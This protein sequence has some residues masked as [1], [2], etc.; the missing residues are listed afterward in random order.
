MALRL[1]LAFS[2]LAIP[3][4][5]DDLTLS[6]S[7][8]AWWRGPNS[9]GVANANP[10]V[11]TT[12]DAETNI[13][14]RAPVPGRG[15]G[16]PVIVGDKVFLATADE[17]SQVQSVICFSRENGDVLWQTEV[18]RGGFEADGR[19]GHPRSTKASSTV[20]CDGERVFTNFWNDNA[21]YTTALDMD[22]KQLWQHKITDYTMH[23]GYGSSPTIYGPLVIVS[24]DNKGGGAIVGLDR[25][26]GKEV[27]RHQRPEKPNYCSPIVHNID[28]K[29]QVILVGCDKILSLD[30]LT[31]KVNWDVAGA[32]TEC[33]TSV[34]SDGKNV[35]TSGGY[36]EDHISVVRADGSGEALWRNNVRVYV[37]S[38]LLHEGH[39]YVANDNGEVH[40]YEV[41]SG[42]LVWE[43]RVRE[44]FATSPVLV[45]DNI[46]ATG[47][48]GKTFIFKASPEGYQQVAENDLPAEDVQASAAICGDRIYM[49]I[50]DKVD[51]ARQEFLYC[52]GK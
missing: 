46:Y 27:W 33:V 50:A 45:G 2:M 9:N 25:V 51:D 41:E 17:S 10:N 15:H 13:V 26:T 43:E 47:M 12:W 19:Q 6:D 24:A 14:W 44:K 38:M 5:A 21:V 16:S 30:P 31:G 48:R 11:P 52:I 29:D 36:P 37:P 20:A 22:G 23:Q 4:M 49:R 32:T 39:I 34:L 35:V 18:H 1:F 28:G 7:D 8:W 3:A 40:C 42:K